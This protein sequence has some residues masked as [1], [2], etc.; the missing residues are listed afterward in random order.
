MQIFVYIIIF[1]CSLSIVQEPSVRSQLYTN[2]EKSAALFFL[3]F[4]QKSK[5][6][7]E[8]LSLNNLITIARKG[9]P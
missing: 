7:F 5:Y 1:I 6:R 9:P 2:I 8:I 3:S 4:S